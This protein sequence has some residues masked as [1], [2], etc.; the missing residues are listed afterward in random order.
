MQQ[1]F[2][3]KIWQKYYKK[4]DNFILLKKFFLGFFQM[5]FYFL[6]KEIDYEW[7][8]QNLL[9]FNFSMQL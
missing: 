4:Y 8:C 1:F 6:K 9:V 3:F 5:L 2:L 7:Y